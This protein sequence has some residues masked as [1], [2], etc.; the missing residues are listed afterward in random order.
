M[1]KILL[2]TLRGANWQELIKNN[3]EILSRRINGADINSKKATF[4]LDNTRMLIFIYEQRRIDTENLIKKALENNF[5]YD[6][7]YICY[8]DTDKDYMIN[9]S[10]VKFNKKKFDERFKHISEAEPYK[11]IKELA[12][13]LKSDINKAKEMF[14]NLCEYIKKKST[15]LTPAFLLHLFLPLDIDMQALQATKNPK[16]YLNDIYTD[17]DKLYKSGKYKEGKIDEHYRQKLYDL[18]YLLEPSKENNRRASPEAKKL[19]STDNPHDDLLKL[20]G[21]SNGK[22]E[23]FPVYNFLESLDTRKKDDMDVTA[24]D[25]CKP[26]NLEIEVN[27]KKKEINSFHNWYCAL[28]SCLSEAEGCEGK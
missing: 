23:E 15:E 12:E 8:H 5:Q 27:G 6:E 26:F 22:S 24:E 9:P 11:Q 1:N 14:D 13:V 20:A 17:L 18:W 3:K 4:P 19:T 2:I 7:L 21:L 28:A 25:L 10:N 16:D